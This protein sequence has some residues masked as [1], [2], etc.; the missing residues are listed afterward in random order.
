MTEYHRGIDNVVDRGPFRATKIWNELI[1]HLRTKVE[2]RRRRWK[3]QYYENCFR[4][5]DVV[6]VLHAYV[7]NNPHLSKNAT[8]SQVRSLCQIL[9]E[10]RV[11]E[12]VAAD[13][14]K[15]D[16]FEDNNRLYRFSS[17]PV[18]H[19]IAS[20]V[21][22]ER[23]TSRRRSLLGQRDKKAA[24]RK[25]LS[26]TPRAQKRF[27]DLLMS[28]ESPKDVSIDTGTQ[29]IPKKR[30]RL[31]LDAGLGLRK[32]K[33]S[34]LS[35]STDQG[36]LI[37]EVWFEVALS[38]LL[39]LTDVPFLEDIL[40]PPIKDDRTGVIV[41]SNSVPEPCIQHSQQIDC[42]K[43]NIDNSEMNN[44]WVTAGME[45]IQLQR[46]CP[47]P[48]RG[49]MGY[50]NVMNAKEAGIQQIL[51]QYYGS[52]VDTLIP[53]NLTDLVDGIL[54]ALA[55]DW[56]KAITFLPM[57]VLMLPSS[58]RRHLKKLLNFMGRSTGTSSGRFIVKK[59]MGAILPKDVK[60]KD[61]GQK[62]VSSMVKNR[63]QMFTVPTQLK[64]HFRRNISYAQRG[65]CPPLPSTVCQQMSIAEY[66][67]QTKLTTCLALNM[68]MTHIIN[69]LQMTLKEKE[70]RLK[71]FQ[72]HHNDLFLQQFP[73][74]Q[75]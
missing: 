61:S 43:E 22:V 72:K 71:L 55:N 31:S 29:E 10:K 18:E 33:L 17:G 57:L 36:D 23:K 13:N 70:E 7:Q 75:L 3:F 41:I 32:N 59:F 63:Q 28:T 54:C 27:A 20:P 39:Q 34:M 2:Q 45:C 40:T 38:R 67:N 15:R 1:E 58:Q 51:L 68:L 8:R 16:S 60:N 5:G 35:S 52:L 21:Q 42:N 65:M 12:C 4:G 25:S 64:E 66:T 6:E 44:V 47:L 24:R 48:Q 62:L 53:S 14:S 46:D 37:S 9:L 56:T 11:I 74:G 69:N 73:S 26:F 50:L 30:R 49:N 19:V